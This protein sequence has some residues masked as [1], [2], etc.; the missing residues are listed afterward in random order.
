MAIEP[1][2]RR[3]LLAAHHLLRFAGVAMLAAGL[4]WFGLTEAVALWPS[5]AVMAAGAAV[6]CIALPF[7]ARY[8]TL[9]D[10]AT[11]RAV[12]LLVAGSTLKLWAVPLVAVGG[13]LL[14]LGGAPG[15]PVALGLAGLGVAAYAYGILARI[16][17]VSLLPTGADYA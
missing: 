7:L 8:E 9:R 16:D 12:R 1:R 14:S 6:G 11:R 10:P 4:L 17:G 15:F 3:R 13:G 5:V 2:V